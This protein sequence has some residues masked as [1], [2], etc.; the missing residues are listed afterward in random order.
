MT[1]NVLVGIPVCMEDM[2][3][4]TSYEWFAECAVCD[5]PLPEES[6]AKKLDYCPECVSHEN[7]HLYHQGRAQDWCRFCTCEDA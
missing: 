6:R 7:A 4:T 2:A 5:G 3:M 1:G